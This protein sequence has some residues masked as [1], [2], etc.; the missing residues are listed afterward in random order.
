M[1]T[2]IHLSSYGID[3]ENEDNLL[4]LIR[5]VHE[6]EGIKRIRLGSLEPRI[7]T[8]EFVQAIAALPKMCPHFHLS[9]QS[10]CNETLKRMNRRYTSEE[11]YRKV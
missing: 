9:L 2:G 4:S 8:E 1:L 5:A 6:I 3:F 11:F 7:I 10:G